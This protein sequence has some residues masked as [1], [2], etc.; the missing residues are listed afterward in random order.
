M[1][2]AEHY[3]EAEE[4]L[5]CARTATDDVVRSVAFANAQVHATL[6][7]AAA[8]ALPLLA[9]A[10]ARTWAAPDRYV[11]AVSEWSRTAVEDSS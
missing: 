11:D 1:I 6:A 3:A 9:G 10:L 5:E 8:T 2:G 7:L 4:L